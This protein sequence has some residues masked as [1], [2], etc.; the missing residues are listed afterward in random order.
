M[1][2]WSLKAAPP[3]LGFSKRHAAAGPAAHPPRSASHRRA[4]PPLCS[5]GHPITGPPRTS[6]RPLPGNK[7]A[8]WAGDRGLSDMGSGND[9]SLDEGL[10]RVSN[11]NLKGEPQSHYLLLQGLIS[12]RQFRVCLRLSAYFCGCLHMSASV[13]YAYCIPVP[14]GLI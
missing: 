10:R 6:Q 4:A 2:A 11:P 12:L 7:S 9:P 5:C 14:Y 13:M 3:T 8:A 1:A